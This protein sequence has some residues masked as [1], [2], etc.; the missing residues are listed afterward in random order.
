MAHQ[1][2]RDP[3]LDVAHQLTPSAPTRRT[4]SKKGLI[5]AWAGH[6]P[7]PTKEALHGLS[8]PHA[9]AFRH[10]ILKNKWLVQY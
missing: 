1:L 7:R 9:L 5:L 3:W 4:P 6:L 10:H 8:D 2:T